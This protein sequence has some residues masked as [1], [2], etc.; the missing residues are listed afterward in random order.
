VYIHGRAA[1]EIPFRKIPQNRLGTV[2]VIPRNKALI[3][4][5]PSVSEESIRYSDWNGTELRKIMIFTK[6][7]FF[8]SSNSKNISN[9]E[10]VNTAGT[11]TIAG[12]PTTVWMPASTGTSNM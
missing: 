10:N 3:S 2:F 6:M 9:I 11:A 4:C 7:L 8:A 5:V 12:S 1:I